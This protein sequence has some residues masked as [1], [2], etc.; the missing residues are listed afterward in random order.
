MFVGDNWIGIEPYGKYFENIGLNGVVGS[1][2]M[3]SRYPEWFL[4]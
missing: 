4:I 3:W 1:A 2:R